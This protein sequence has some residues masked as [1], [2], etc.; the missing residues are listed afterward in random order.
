MFR[1]PQRK[2]IRV[3]EHALLLRATKNFHAVKAANQM[4]TFLGLK[5]SYETLAFL[6]LFIGSEVVGASKLKENSIVQLI[7]NAIN[8][9]K[10]FRTEDER[11]QKAKELLK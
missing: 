4:L 1:V 2:P 3:K 8:S 9:L 6:A 10:P 7:L 5:V 11:L